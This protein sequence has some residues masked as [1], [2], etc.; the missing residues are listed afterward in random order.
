MCWFKQVAL[1]VPDS[2]LSILGSRGG[3]NDL[4]P[5][6]VKA[7]PNQETHFLSAQASDQGG[8]DN[9]SWFQKTFLI[10]INLR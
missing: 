4:C 9:R 7:G 10:S 1:S 6:A 2:Q 8:G 5:S 3:K